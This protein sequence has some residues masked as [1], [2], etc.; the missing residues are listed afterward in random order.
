MKAS[1][2]AW[3]DPDANGILLIIQKFFAAITAI[4]KAL[5]IVK[6]EETTAAPETQA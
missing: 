4:L 6:D 2:V 3:N 1:T 5:G